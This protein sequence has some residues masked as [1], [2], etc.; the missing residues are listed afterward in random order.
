MRISLTFALVTLGGLGVS[1]LGQSAAEPP[2]V[3]RSTYVL[4]T[5]DQIVIRALHAEEISDK[6]FRI[7]SDG[8]LNLPLIGR[9]Q[10]AGRSVSDLEAELRTRLGTYYLKPEVTVT[11]TELRSQP[12]SILAR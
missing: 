2:P 9:I 5:D 4:G 12:V 3:A 1:A 8:Y 10:A 6:P 11:V 7:A